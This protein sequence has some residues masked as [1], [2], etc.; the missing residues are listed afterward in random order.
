MIQEHL[1]FDEQSHVY[2]WQ[3]KEAPSVNQILSSVGVM[4]K[5]SGYYRSCG[6]SDFAKDDNAA[7]FGTAFHKIAAI[8]LRG[9]VPTFP[10]IMTP[11]VTQLYEYLDKRK[12]ALCTNRNLIVLDWKTSTT[13][14]K[15]WWFQLAGYAEIVR[16]LVKNKY[17]GC[18]KK[19]MLIEQ[20]M[21]HLSQGYAGT[22]DLVTGNFSSQTAEY[23]TVMVSKDKYEEHIHTSKKHVNDAII[24]KSILNVYKEYAK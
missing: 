14:K 15:H 24:W 20:P 1:T 9:G 13:S 7:S 22:P 21:F 5:K 8:V 18:D 10:E 19:S 16:F 17:V 6:Y 2:R 12:D 4:D 11:W 3:G 23:V